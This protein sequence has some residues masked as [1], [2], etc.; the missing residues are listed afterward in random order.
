[1]KLTVKPVDS[2]SG[3][4]GIIVGNCGFALWRTRVSILEEPNFWFAS[5]LV[6]LFGK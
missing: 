5:F 4:V 2:C 6:N 3:G 1:M